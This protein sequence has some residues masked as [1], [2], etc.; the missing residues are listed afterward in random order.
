MKKNNIDLL[1]SIIESIEKGNGRVS[2]CKLVNIKYDTLIDWIN[3]KSSRFNLE[4]SERVKKAENVG[5]IRIKE[6]CE[7]VS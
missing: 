5:N 6:I 7:N 4:F 1:N 2:T 3:P